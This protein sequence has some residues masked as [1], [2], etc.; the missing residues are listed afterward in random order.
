MAFLAMSFFCSSLFAQTGFKPVIKPPKTSLELS[1]SAPT[2][3][4]A[5]PSVQEIFKKPA[6]RKIQQHGIGFGIGQNVLMG[7]YGKYGK[8]KIT[9]DLLYSY[10]A[11]Y[12]FD[13]LIDAHYSVQQDNGE[14]MR[15]TGLATSIKGRLVEFDNLSPYLLGG[16]GFYAPRAYREKNTGGKK[17]TEDKITFGFNFGAGLDLRL[18]DQFVVGLMTQLHTPFTI[19]QEGQSDLKGYYAKFLLTGMYLF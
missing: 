8:D 7:N 17:W 2:K 1:D 13:V 11:S 12:S 18:N 3:T 15:T 16:V 6:G 4:E 5:L 9:L 14:K 10:A 19:A